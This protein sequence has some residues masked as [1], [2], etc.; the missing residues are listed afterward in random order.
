VLSADSALPAHQ[1]RAA[2]DRV[3]S[4]VFFVV[5]HRSYT[6]F[7]HRAY[8]R[9][10]YRVISCNNHVI[11]TSS[12]YTH[13]VVRILKNDYEHT[14]KKGRHFTIL[15]HCSHDYYIYISSII[16]FPKTPHFTPLFT[17]LKRKI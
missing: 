5:I 13:V 10:Y 1:P 2:H 9:I 17:E 12:L 15:I 8:I 4:R 3:R 11:F 14:R 6:V 7:H 16:Y